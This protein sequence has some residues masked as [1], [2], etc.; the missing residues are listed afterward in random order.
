MWAVG[1]WKMDVLR[2]LEGGVFTWSTKAPWPVRLGFQD[3]CCCSH[4]I[5][6]IGCKTSPFAPPNPPQLLQS[7]LARK[8]KDSFKQT[9]LESSS[10]PFIECF[11]CARHRKKHFMCMILFNPHDKPVKKACYL[12]CGRE[13]WNTNI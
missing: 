8:C 4:Y 12:H 7:F 10:S 2:P 3:Q 5:N 11:L 9:L 1:W 13:N 6:S